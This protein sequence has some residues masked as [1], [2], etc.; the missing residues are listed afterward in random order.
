MKT[1]VL[2]SLAL[3]IAM[4]TS[5]FSWGQVNVSVDHSRW[6]SVPLEKK[7]GVNIPFDISMQD[8]ENNVSAIKD[9]QLRLVRIHNGWGLEGEGKLQE[10]TPITLQDGKLQ[11]DFTTLD[12]VLA[13]IK[14]TGAKP[15]IVNGYGPQALSAQFNMIPEDKFELWGEL[16]KMVAEHVEQLAIPAEI[17]VWDNVSDKNYFAGDQA[18]YTALLGPAFKSLQGFNYVKVGYG[19]IEDWNLWSWREPW[20]ATDW[21]QIPKFISSVWLNTA[22]LDH[23]LYEVTG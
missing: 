14:E 19:G 13:L 4:G 9:L 12:K 23:H 15:T 3:S 1:N 5:F 8:F 20:N 21:K 17:E 11:Y 18:A 10:T 7:Y 2:K 16:N 6:A 22:C